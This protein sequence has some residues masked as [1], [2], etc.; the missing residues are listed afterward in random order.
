VGVHDV[1]GDTVTPVDVRDRVPVI[2][3]RQQLESA[4]WRNVNPRDP[5]ALE[6]VEAVL[7]AADSYASAA[8][9]DPAGLDVILGPL[10]LAEAAGEMFG[11]AS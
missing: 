10:R 1:R 4:L 3:A 9:A 8:V 6:I 2:R 5:R 11:R 7:A